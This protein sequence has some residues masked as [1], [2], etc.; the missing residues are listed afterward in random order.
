VLLFAVCFYQTMDV[1]GPIDKSNQRIQG[2]NGS[3]SRQVEDCQKA[4]AHSG[5][6]LFGRHSG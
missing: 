5:H 1:E 4:V 6:F 3:V 2:E